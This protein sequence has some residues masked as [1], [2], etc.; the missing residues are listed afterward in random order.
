MKTLITALLFGTFL[1]G[2]ASAESYRNERWDNQRRVWHGAQTG[3]LTAREAAR[4]EREQR[5]LDRQ[6]QRDRRDGG[7]LTYR[8]RRNLQRQ[9]NR[10]ERQ[11]YRD[12]R[13]RDRRWW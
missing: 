5:K 8:E 9:Q 2:S 4:L 1:V 11:T 7:G 12:L 3:R 10:L 6:Y 13:D